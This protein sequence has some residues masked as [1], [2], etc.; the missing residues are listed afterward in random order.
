[1]VVT[2][3]SPARA[4]EPDE[5]ELRFD[6]AIFD[7]G[8]QNTGAVVQDRDGFLWLGT[9]GGGL[10]RYDAYQTTFYKPGGP[11]SLP[12]TYIYALYEDS[13]GLIWIGTA[14]SG[15]VK[16]DKDTN[17]FTQY[18]YDSDDPTSIAGDEWILGSMASI[19]EDQDG[20]LWVGS[21]GGLSALDKQTGVFTRY[22]NDPSDPHSLSDNSVRAVFV[23]RAGV[24]WVGTADGL[25]RFDKQ[26][27]MFTRY[28][29]DP[30]DPLSFNGE[31]VNTI[32]ED[33]D[34]LLW[35]AT[36]G[37][38]LFSFDPDVE[39]FTQ[40]AHNP[41]N[42]NS[43]SSDRIWHICGD[44]TGK[45]WLAY[46]NSEYAGVS[47]FDRQTETFTHYTYNPDD[48]YSLSSETIN[49]VYEDSAGILWII[50]NTGLVD[51]LDN[52]K[53]RFKVHRNIPGNPNSLMSNIVVSVYEDHDGT[54][55]IGTVPGLQK[56]DKHT[57]TFTEYI[58]DIYY[59]GI[60]ED[61]AGTLWLGSYVP[62]GLHIFNRETGQIVESYINDPDDPTSLGSTVQVNMII[63]DRNDPNILWMVTTD[64]GLEKFDKQAETF[65]HYTHDPDDP[66][67]LGGNNAFTL[68][69]DQEG[70]VWIP[71]LG[72]GLNRLDPRTDTITRYTHNPDDP[73]TISA[74]TVNVVF[75]DSAGMLWLGTAVGFDKLD[76]ATCVFTHYNDST[77]FPV[78]A[79]GSINQD[80]QGNLWMG[81]LGGGGLIKFDPRTEALKVYKAS[82]GLQGDVF[83][84]L[85]GIRDQDGEMWFG[86]PKG[87]NSFY[88]EEIVDNSFIPPVALTALKQGGEDLPLNAAPERAQEITL[89]WRHN[90]F[91]FEYTALNFTRA[92]KNQYRY[93]L[94][95]L[96]MD[97]FDAGTRRFGR[98]SGLPG[99]DYTLRILGSNNDGIWNEQGVSL[100]VQ[101]IPPFWRTGWF[102]GLCA[103]IVLG[104]GLAVFRFRTAQL[105]RFNLELEQQVAARTA[106]LANA[107]AELA[108]ATEIAEK[109]RERAEVASHAKSDF[110][111]NM[112]HELRT[113]LNAILGYVQ[114]LKREK[115]VSRLQIDGLNIIQQSG[116]HLLT[117]IN[118]VLDLA[119]IE[120]GKMDLYPVDF[121]FPGFLEGI[122]GIILARAEQKDLAFV[123]APQLPLPS[124][125]HADETRLR[126]VLLNLLGNAAKFTGQGQ[127]TFKVS[128]LQRR[129][130]GTSE[131]AL[132]RF[133]VIDTGMGIAPEHLEKIFA[134]FEQ[135]GDARRRAE[136]TG[137]GLTISRR[138]VQAMGSELQVKSAPGQGST[139][140]FEIEL[141]LVE[142]AV[143]APAMPAQTIIAYKFP[144]QSPVKV[145][146]V[147]DKAYNRSLITDLLTPLGFAVTEAE[148]GQQGVAQAQALQPDLIVVDLV[149]PVMDGFEAVQ[150][151][152][153]IPA[154]QSTVII[155]MSASVIEDDKQKS[156]A[157]GCDAFVPKPVDVAQL[158]SVIAERLGLEWVYETAQVEKAPE[159]D[160][161]I[162][163]P[164]ETLD[165]LLTWLEQGD[166]RALRE[167][168]THAS[169]TDEPYRAF[170]GALERLAS[171][172]AEEEIRALLMQFR[173]T[174]D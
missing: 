58:D 160:S 56:Y 87:L 65:T 151:I 49:R 164:P 20:I 69:Q 9:T 44:N 91:E 30:D 24:L 111:A 52:R 105:Q 12:D 172:Y 19:V 143:T 122:A 68:Y 27:G 109:A 127:V 102:Y 112:S 125:V 146:V 11:N 168:A 148:D 159:P 136:G 82:D 121:Y 138:L 8:T 77:G 124:G 170:A 76:R 29:H 57:R 131:Q 153:Q 104:G 22:Q 92:E 132:L 144:R 35:L 96:D 128:E 3:V 17:A 133:E 34:G 2:G 86:G 37:G 48:P 99:G 50:N 70:H 61:S 161:L 46:E 117:L 116:A 118:D 25:N 106:E 88:P 4:Q 149:M 137:L 18:R 166:L 98:Y 94:E 93:M 73:A 15:L 145:L 171:A 90:F 7:T 110:L 95:G 59:P 150:A 45:I 62:A 53:P 141:P 129:S 162:P 67:S 74:D 165:A 75:E 38:G 1:M 71:T 5:A 108:Q 31:I 83:Y 103:L 39:I 41:D 60:Y 79:I 119:K 81:S 115:A 101:V 54:I 13:E 167:W 135:V 72:G 169:A 40:Y 174:R 126:Q 147:D 142:M 97:W 55:W 163:P 154:L 113:P 51:K 42:P 140:W 139:F 64:S 156:L 23:D 6:R 173:E 158:L 26:T 120:A 89:D 36:L 107:N 28:V 152:R 47:V 14:G 100:R 157:I 43:P 80:A 123:Y 21:S 155:A 85:N 84:P 10:V 134:P 16:Y 63:E 32:I 78:S 66:N 114:I 33:Q 130:T